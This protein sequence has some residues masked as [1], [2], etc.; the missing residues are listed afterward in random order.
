MV[1]TELDRPIEKDKCDNS[2]SAA[3]LTQSFVSNSLWAKLL[4]LVLVLIITAEIYLS[5][6]EYGLRDVFNAFGMVVGTLVGLSIWMILV[7]G[8]PAAVGKWFFATKVGGAV[9]RQAKWMGG[10]IGTGAIIVL[11][12]L[13][14]AVTIFAIFNWILSIPSWAAV[15]I[16]LLLAILVRMRN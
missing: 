3:L 6:K 13:L 15:I 11:K 7:V 16:F 2:E 9:K 4:I 12:W 10:K 1:N 14:I 5:I 8:V